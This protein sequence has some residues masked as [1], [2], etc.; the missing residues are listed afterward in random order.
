MSLPEELRS[1]N[2]H[3]TNCHTFVERVSVR[4]MGHFS[5]GLCVCDGWK[6]DGNESFIKKKLKGNG[7]RERERKSLRL[8]P[9]RPKE[10]HP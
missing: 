9:W 3:S 10:L 2:F 5:D 8:P 6:E 1:V 7:E 4:F